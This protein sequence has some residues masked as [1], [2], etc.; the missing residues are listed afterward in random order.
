MDKMN[1]FTNKYYSVYKKPNGLSA[2]EEKNIDELD[3]WI[4]FVIKFFFTK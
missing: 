4:S 2:I 3:D 1:E